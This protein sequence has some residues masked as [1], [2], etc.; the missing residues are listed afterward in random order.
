MAT[1][2][3]VYQLA[4]RYAVISVNEDLSPA[5]LRVIRETGCYDRMTSMRSIGKPLTLPLG[6][7]YAPE[8]LEEEFM[9]IGR[10]QVEEEKAQL[11]VIACTVISLFL[12]PGARERLTKQLGVIV[13]DVQEV[14]LKTAEMLASLG[15]AHS[16]REYPQIEN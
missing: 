11:L 13:V 15:L 2:H 10:K 3:L 14:A 9:R 12:N 6:E 1:F 4:R 5:F 8:E 16:K 7:F